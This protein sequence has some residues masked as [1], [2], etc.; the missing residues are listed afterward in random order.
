MNGGTCQVTGTG[1]TYTCSCLAGYSGTNCQIC[2][3]YYFINYLGKN[4][5]NFLLVNACFNN[6][7]LN[8]GT[9]TTSGNSYVCTC[10]TFYS[11]INCQIC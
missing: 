4:I 10:P 2:K 11:G 6:P 3:C 8:G 7:C 1:T 9:C 5:I